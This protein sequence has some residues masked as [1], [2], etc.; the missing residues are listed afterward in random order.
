M[1]ALGRNEFLC[2]DAHVLPL[3]DSL[4]LNDKTVSI[5]DMPMKTDIEEE[6]L[7]ISIDTIKALS[8]P[9]WTS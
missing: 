8:S 3:D 4:Y 5:L 6:L 2:Q 1:D 7:Y 9:F